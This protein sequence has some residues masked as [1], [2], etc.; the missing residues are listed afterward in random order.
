MVKLRNKVPAAEIRKTTS[1]KAVADNVTRWG[2]KHSMLKSYMQLRPHLTNF[3]DGDVEALI[4]S[5]CVHRQL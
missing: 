1:L 2:S 4:P 5:T 3:D